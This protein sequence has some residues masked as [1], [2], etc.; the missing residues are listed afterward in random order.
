MVATIWLTFSISRILSLCSQPI[1]LCILPSDILLNLCSPSLD[2]HLPHTGR[3]LAGPH[4]VLP[5]AQFLRSLLVW[6]GLPKCMHGRAIWGCSSQILRMLISAWAVLALFLWNPSWQVP[7]HRTERS[8]FSEL[9]LHFGQWEFPPSLLLL[10]VVSLFPE[11]Y[12]ILGYNAVYSVEYQLYNP[13]DC[14]L[15]NHR[16]EN[17]K[18]YIVYFLFV[19]KILWHAR[20]FT[21]VAK[22]LS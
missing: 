8:S 17:F 11:E 9:F 4:A 10:V 19:I 15:H 21:T 16:C 22:Q 14:T 1:M 18:S 12:N 7:S 20:L 3:R 13:E 2:C 6:F 5:A